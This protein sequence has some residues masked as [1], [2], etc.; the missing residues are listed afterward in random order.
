[1]LKYTLND[2]SSIC[3]KKRNKG[4]REFYNI[5]LPLNLFD[6]LL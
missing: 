6:H 3:E 5:Q 2:L 1:M 4:S